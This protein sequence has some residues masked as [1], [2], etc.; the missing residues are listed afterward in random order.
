MAAVFLASLLPSPG[1]SDT[2]EPGQTGEAQTPAGFV[3]LPERP[4]PLPGKVMCEYGPDW[5]T[6]TGPVTAPADGQVSAKGIVR[7]TIVTNMGALPVV[8]D[9]SLA[10]CTVNEFVHLAEQGFYNTSSCGNDAHAPVMT[11]RRASVGATN[12]GWTDETFPLPRHLRGY[13]TMAE[14]A[15]PSVSVRFANGQP[16]AASTVFGTLSQSGMKAV[17]SKRRE[18]ADSADG[19]PSAVVVNSVDVQS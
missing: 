19:D 1:D 6:P 2:T 4:A 11:C 8:L 18:N 10:P 17:E 3:A 9:R 5:S 12:D 13:L 16:G 7:A 15:Y 14:P